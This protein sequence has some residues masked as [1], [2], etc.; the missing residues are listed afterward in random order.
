MRIQWITSLESTTTLTAGNIYLRVL[1][2][3]WRQTGHIQCQRN[4]ISEA[5]SRSLDHWHIAQ[6]QMGALMF[7]KKKRRAV[8]KHVCSLRPHGPFM[9]LI[10]FSSNHNWLACSSLQDFFMSWTVFYLI[11]NV[12][13]QPVLYIQYSWGVGEPLWSNSEWLQNCPFIRHKMC[14]MSQIVL[15]PQWNDTISLR[16]TTW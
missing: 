14:L 7:E 8:F 15:E 16:Q 13:S 10:Y 4:V 1:V 2:E 6:K 12:V 9:H 5:T 11:V 3:G